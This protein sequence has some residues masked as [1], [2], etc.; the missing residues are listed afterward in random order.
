MNRPAP[1]DG[2]MACL[3]QRLNDGAH[4]LYHSPQNCS[5]HLD[6]TRSLVLVRRHESSPAAVVMAIANTE[7]A[8]FVFAGR[9]AAAAAAVVEAVEVAEAIAVQM[10]LSWQVVRVH[11]A[12]EDGW[13]S[14]YFR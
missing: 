6:S 11:V 8:E 7:Q 1:N 10:S 4:D 9:F 12:W 3:E 5:R 13:S 2:M 14:L